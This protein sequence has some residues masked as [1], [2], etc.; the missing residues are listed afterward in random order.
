VPAPSPVGHKHSG[1]NT[2]EEASECNIG[3]DE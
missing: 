1:G 2:Q 3:L